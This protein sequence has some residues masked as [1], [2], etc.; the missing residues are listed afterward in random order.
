MVLMP[1][2]WVVIAKELLRLRLVDVDSLHRQP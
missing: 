1:F 2:E